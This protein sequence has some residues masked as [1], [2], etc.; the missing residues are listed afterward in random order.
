MI[1]LPACSKEGDGATF[2]VKE[3]Q[4]F[5]E[6]RLLQSSDGGLTAKLTVTEGPLD[7]G[8]VSVIG[9][10]FDGSYPGPTMVVSPGES[11]R[12]EFVNRLDE[13]TNIHFHGFH[14]SPSGIADNVLRSIP[15]NSTTA[16]DVPVPPEM[17]PG[18]Y[19]YHSHEHGISEEQVFSG[20]SGT[21]IVRGLEDKLPPE[22]RGVPQKVFALKDLQVKD[23]RIVTENINS[24]APTTR[25]VN[26]LV[27]PRVT[28]AP[29]ETQLWRFANIGADIWYNL[30]LGGQPF[31]V[32]AEDANP[33]GTVWSAT[34]LLLPP[35]KRYEVLVQGPP[36][37]TYQ[38]KTLAYSTG[39]EGDS[40]P[41][42]ILSTVESTGAVVQPLALPTS[43][44][45]LPD[46]PASEV[47][48]QREFVF[49]ESSNGN[50]FYINGEQFNHDKVNVTTT[51]GDTEEW[52]I[53]NVSGEQH[54]FHIHV[55]DFQV[56][57][58]NGQPYDAKSLQDTVPLPV[59][60]QVV[61]RQRFADYTGKFV[62][63]CHILAHEDGGMMGLIEVVPQA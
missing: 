12:L 21:I 16:V 47:D 33:V 50:D 42:R 13:A 11:I 52:L 43:L 53:T 28:I 60:G 63:H 2:D 23:G 19:W 26:G 10:S 59:K 7:D 51:L 24:D 22:L 5:G 57:S 4:P 27:D 62:Y 56:I 32:V 20:L 9:K 31:N 48:R 1:G 34:E 39:E 55:N 44:G 17:A 6:P 3:G 46:I 54:P 30:S 35:G 15:A 37:G 29:G 49:S 40:Y 41:E 8:G 18:L 14:T 38:L 25:T 36:A 45:P 58:V 61:I